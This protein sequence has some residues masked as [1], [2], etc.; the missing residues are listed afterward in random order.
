MQD[1]Y[2]CIQEAQEERGA[3]NQYGAWKGVVVRRG[4]FTSCMSARGY[5]IDPNGILIAAPG[6]EI[7]MV[8]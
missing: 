5:M 4:V 2:V 7:K 3:A 1:R 6:T 8:D